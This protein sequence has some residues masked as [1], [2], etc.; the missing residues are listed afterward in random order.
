MGAG[1]GASMNRLALVY[2]SR[3]YM[4]IS[5]LCNNRGGRGQQQQ[6]LDEREGRSRKESGKTGV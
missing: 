2:M 1:V 4:C 3:S 6:E 5:L